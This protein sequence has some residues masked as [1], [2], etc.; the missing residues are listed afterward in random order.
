MASTIPSSTAT[1]FDLLPFAA[2][3]LKNVD[4]CYQFATVLVRKKH[5]LCV[6]LE[7]IALLIFLL[8]YAFHGAGSAQ[9][10]AN[11]RRPLYSRALAAKIAT[12]WCLRLIPA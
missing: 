10:A 6:N 8:R 4:I 11:R 5:V 1:G 9:R 3:K 7:H 12:S 2:A